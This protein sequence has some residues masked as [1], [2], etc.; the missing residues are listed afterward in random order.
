VA[1]LY[2]R[3]VA[4]EVGQAGQVGK[5][6]EGLRMGF[7][8]AK[9]T[10]RTPNKATIEVYN[11]SR[12]SS[13]AFNEPG[14]V[15]RFLAGYGV[16]PAIFIG[17]VD[18]S[19]RNP[20]GVDIVTKIEA[21]DGGRKFRDSRISKTFA[22]EL[23]VA[24]AI[25]ELAAA[26]GIP[27]GNLGAI[28]DVRIGQGTTLDGPVRDELDRMAA[29]IGAEWSLHD[30]ELQILTPAQTTPQEAVLLTPDTGLVGSPVPTK[31]GIQVTALLQPKI[32]PGRRFRLES[33]RYT[34]VYKAD[35]VEMSG[36][37]GWA[38]DFYSKIQA[39]EVQ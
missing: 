3:Q 27:I 22:S 35:Q 12:D 39:H 14:A 31:T 2:H 26:A 15:V 16:P 1:T 9:G 36:D 23:T 6:W 37:S 10:G 29:I 30:G 38:N 17:D 13:A 18:R 5:R 25:E 24:N 11:L 4:I 19:V 8:V 32:V 33:L 28:P 34:G 21:S 7:S 20:S